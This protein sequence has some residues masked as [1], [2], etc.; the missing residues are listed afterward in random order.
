LIIHKVPGSL[1]VYLISH[2]VLQ[3]IV[4]IIVNDSKKEENGLTGKK[5]EH[6]EK[7]E[8][9]DIKGQFLQFHPGNNQSAINL[10]KSL[11]WV[12]N[13]G[14]NHKNPDLMECNNSQDIEEDD[15]ENCNEM[16]FQDIKEGNNNKVKNN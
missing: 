3:M 5:R 11:G 6:Q 1:H 10:L 14:N 4:V 13:T 2:H 15:F 7:P 8:V 9:N 16:S 12:Y